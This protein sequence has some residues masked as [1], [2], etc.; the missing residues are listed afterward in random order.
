MVEIFTLYSVSV[1]LLS[2]RFQLWKRSVSMFL[3]TLALVW[4]AF[5]D[6]GAD[7]MSIHYFGFILFHFLGM[8]RA[9]HKPATDT[10]SGVR[11]A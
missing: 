1:F 11:H 9:T 10:V 7:P 4:C 6:D 3:F 8:I 2:L 5:T